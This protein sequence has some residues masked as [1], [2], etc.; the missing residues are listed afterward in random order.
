MPN[1]GTVLAPGDDPFRLLGVSEGASESDI[2]AAYLR[3][4]KEFPPDR[5]P[6]Q[7]ER[8]RDA[9]SL[10]GDPR[11]RARMAIQCPLPIAPL[12]GL[13]DARQSRRRYVGPEPWLAVLQ[14]P[15]S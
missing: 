8:I 14:K 1:D 5:A 11:R 12:A 7:F 15:K 6:E 10:L 13:L 2:R 4:I 3:K 9:Y